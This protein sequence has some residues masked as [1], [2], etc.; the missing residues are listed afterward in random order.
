[1]SSTDVDRRPYALV[2]GASSGIG[3]ELARQFVAHDFDVLLVAEDAGVSAVLAELGGGGRAEAVQADL[4]VADEVERVWAHVVASGR[5]LSAAALNAGVGNAG[6]FVET[7]LDADLDLVALNVS[8]TVHLA[9]R[10]L[11]DMVARGEGRV[12][13]TSSVAATMPGPN[14][15]TYAASKAFVQSFAEAVRREVAEAGVSVTALMPGPTDTAFFDRAGMEG[16]RADEGHKD[17]PADVAR[18]GFDALMAG[19][20]HVVAGATRNR[21]QTALAKV[22]PE[23]A[24]AAVHGAQAKP[25]DTD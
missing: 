25:G 12:L 23:T 5:P 14:Y 8:S 4:R 19:K 7:S 17:D 3:L 18:D 16:S 15:A 13:F 11:A 24:T 9:K 6:A 20:D 10:V 1:M 22:L 21:V 2:T